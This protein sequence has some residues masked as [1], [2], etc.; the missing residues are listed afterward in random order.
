MNSVEVGF[1]IGKKHWNKGYMSE[2]LKA[3]IG[4]LFESGIHKVRACH[5][6]E[7]KASGKVMEKCGMHYEGIRKDDLFYHDK[8]YDTVNYYLLEDEYG[9]LY[10]HKTE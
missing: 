2:A 3:M 7:N 10:D 8:Y 6:R 5:I 1:A 9:T 4:L